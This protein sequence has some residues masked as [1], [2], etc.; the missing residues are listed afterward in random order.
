MHR[1]AIEV[2]GGDGGELTL[3]YPDRLLVAEIRASLT[4]L[5]K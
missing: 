4:L 2:I 5:H 1:H 3:R